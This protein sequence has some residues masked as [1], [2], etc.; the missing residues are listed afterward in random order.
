MRV[1][2]LAAL[3]AATCGLATEATRAGAVATI[4]SGCLQVADVPIAIRLRVERSGAS[5]KLSCTN[6]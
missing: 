6:L 3:V 5:H 2:V 1:S 4:F